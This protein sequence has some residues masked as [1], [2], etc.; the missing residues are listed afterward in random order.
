MRADLPAVDCRDTVPVK[1]H[2]DSSSRAQSILEVSQASDDMREGGAEAAV[3]S[4]C[5]GVLE[6]VGVKGKA[7]GY[8]PG[9][10]IWFALKSN[11]FRQ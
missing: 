4:V 8:S 11:E 1:A 2:K 5:G 7:R 9:A 6:R 10:H 3:L